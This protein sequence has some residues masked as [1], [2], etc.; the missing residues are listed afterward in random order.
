MQILQ[1]PTKIIQGRKEIDQESI[2]NKYYSILTP[3]ENMYAPT[4]EQ[5]REI[6]LKKQQE[7][8]ERRRKEEEENQDQVNE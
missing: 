8:E 2:T 5:L 1:K 6:E 3:I 4:P 7:E